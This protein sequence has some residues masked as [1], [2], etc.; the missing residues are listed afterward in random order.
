MASDLIH[1]LVKQAL[2]ND[3]WQ[4]THDP[5]PIKLGMKIVVVNTQKNEIMKWIN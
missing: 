1:N 3:G 5:Y 4:I 2:I